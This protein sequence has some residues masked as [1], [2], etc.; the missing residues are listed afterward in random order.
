MVSNVVTIVQLF[1]AYIDTTLPREERWE[2]LKT[3][4]DFTCNCSE[5]S[6]PAPYVDIRSVV[7]CPSRCG[8]LCAVEKG[9]VRSRATHDSDER[10]TVDSLCNKCATPSKIRKHFLDQ[11]EAAKEGLEKAQIEQW[12][13]RSIYSFIFFTLHAHSELIL[14]VCRSC[15]CAYTYTQL[16]QP[17][18]ASYG[19]DVSPPPRTPTTASVL[20]HRCTCD[21][22]ESYKCRH[23][24]ERGSRG[25]FH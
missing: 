2:A 17:I 25:C 1:G 21:G 6:R 8:G 13:G 19:S 15:S 3:T 24:N 11:V 23:R 10:Y 22:S 18:E 12:S 9:R 5:C 4:Y 7:V 14:R 20:T 16:G